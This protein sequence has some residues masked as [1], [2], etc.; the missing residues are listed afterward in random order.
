[1][2]NYSQCIVQPA[3]IVIATNPINIPNH[4][5]KSMKQELEKL[6]GTIL[7]DLATT[8]MPFG[9][10]K[11]VLLCQLPMAYLDWFKQKG[12]PKGRIGLLLQTLYELHLNGLTY[13]LNP[14]KK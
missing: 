6:D 5:C 2:I 1:M 3:N 9:K 12:Y 10:Y 4:T 13:L 7:I 14:L 8:T 11:G